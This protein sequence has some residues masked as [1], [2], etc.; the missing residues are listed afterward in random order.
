MGETDLTDL[1]KKG[2]AALEKRVPFKYVLGGFIAGLIA[3]AALC[4]LLKVL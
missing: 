2:D 4:I 1:G 3:G